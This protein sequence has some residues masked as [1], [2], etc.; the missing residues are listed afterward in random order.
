MKV[1][2]IRSKRECGMRYRAY[3]S[4]TRD[5]RE[6]TLPTDHSH[7]AL[8]GTPV[9]PA[10]ISVTRR[11]SDRP[12]PTS[13]STPKN[14]PPPRPRNGPQRRLDKVVPYQRSRTERLVFACPLT[15]SR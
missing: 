14:K 9:Q 4:P 5:T 3:S 7:A 6:R 2:T 15:W 8:A 1:G 11:R 10:N 12:S 13:R